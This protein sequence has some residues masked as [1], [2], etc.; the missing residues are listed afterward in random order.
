VRRIVQGNSGTLIYAGGDDV[1]AL[2]PTAKA[3]D[4][5]TKLA[6]SYASRIPADPD[7]QAAT[8]SGG[9]AVVHYKEDLR[10]AL[11]AARDAEK[12]AKA[13]GRDA[14]CLSICRRSGE[15]ASAVLPWAMTQSLYKL[16]ELF[17][18]KK[19]DRWAYTLRR[20]LLTL[21]GLPWKA[22]RCE[23]LRV[24]SRVE[25]VGYR[26]QLRG[27]IGNDKESGFL[28]GYR[29]SLQDSERQHPLPDSDVVAGFVTLC[30]SASFLARGRDS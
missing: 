7:G 4:C 24:A 3:I 8:I 27:W 28:D 13:A 20:E 17:L 25:D 29:N 9:I 14:L 10:F 26:E 6:E 19:S 16:V 11:Q 30:Q 1:L 2:L 15:H 5:A 23:V 18:Q 12:L 21:Q 22:I